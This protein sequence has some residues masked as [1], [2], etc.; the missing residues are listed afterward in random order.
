MAKGEGKRSFGND[1]LLI[2]KYFEHVKHVEV[3]IMGDK[4]GN[5]YHCFERECSVQRRHQ[6]V[7]EETPSPA[8]DSGL[9]AR[10]TE[11]AVTIGKLIRY[12]GAG[13]VEFIV[14]ANTK[15]FYF[16]EVNTRLQV[17]HP[18]TEAITGLD[19]VEL[20]IRV[21]SGESLSAY[22]LDQL[23]MNG[24]A[25]ESRLYAEDPNN[26]FFPCTGRIILW[27]Q[28][29]EPG[30]KYPRYDTGVSS[31]SVISVFYDPLISKVTV[32]APN[33]REAILCMEQALRETV[34]LGL[35]TNKSFLLQVL[36]HEEFIRGS[37]VTR[38]VDQMQTQGITLGFNIADLKSRQTC[39]IENVD[40]ASNRSLEVLSRA[41]HQLVK[42]ENGASS[43]FNLGQEVSVVAM[44][45]NFYRRRALQ[46]HW[47]L[48][49]S[50]WRVVRWRPDRETFKI[51][52]DKDTEISLEYLCRTETY[53]S[54][55]NGQWSFFCRFVT[56]KN[57][58]SKNSRVDVVDKV[59]P[60]FSVQLLSVTPLNKNYTSGR[61][62]CVISNQRKRFS[63]AQATNCTPE[64]SFDTFVH[65]V[66]WE[67]QFCV[68]RMDPRRTS[69]NA[70]DDP[71]SSYTSS[72][73]CRVLKL[74]VENKSK[75]KPGQPLLTMESMK[76]ETRLYSKH[77][78]E[79]Q[80][81]VKEGQVV[82]AGTQ[83]LKVN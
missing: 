58:G 6:K 40:P 14:D 68:T 70:D 2:E 52:L 13:T 22:G 4:H 47:K 39:P 18:I 69:V 46:K 67:R 36:K 60:W 80:F 79:V 37:Y 54:N 1:N 66:D 82:E 21:A 5:V 30:N 43:I 49:P 61:I 53:Q 45:W 34:C 63:V 55:T 75:V 50:G 83:L 81:F 56:I 20:Q 29:V 33:R 38:L 25:I 57:M 72:M 28:R 3:Q 71:V 27:N 8:L 62:I 74:L 11:A 31:G 9:R 59:G 44:L 65:S 17:E 78:G 24:H 19:L 10:M 15:Q 32:W 77:E 12:E 26:N 76:M 48:V 7:I 64:E 41:P 42:A 16:L 23:R 73:P 35:V 51:D